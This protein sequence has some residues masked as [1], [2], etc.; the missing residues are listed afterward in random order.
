MQDPI[1]AQGSLM[2]ISYSRLKWKQYALKSTKHFNK[3]KQKKLRNSMSTFR[4]QIL[5]FK[6]NKRK[7]LTR[8]WNNKKK[9]TGITSNQLSKQCRSHRFWRTKSKEIGSK[10]GSGEAIRAAKATEDEDQ[11]I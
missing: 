1:M 4:I 6:R 5:T 10:Q 9:E 3:E 11:K 7:K 2:V 8:Y